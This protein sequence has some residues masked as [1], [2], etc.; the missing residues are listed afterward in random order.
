MN[1]NRVAVEASDQ[2]IS[3]PAEEARGF[4]AAGISEKTCSAR[5]VDYQL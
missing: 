4:R 5:I 3:I 2:E 1:T